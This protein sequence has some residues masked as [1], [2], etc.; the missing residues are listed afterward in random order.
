[1]KTEG[2]WNKRLFNIENVKRFSYAI[3]CIRLYTPPYTFVFTH[4]ISY[5]TLPIFVYTVNGTG[6]NINITLHLSAR[7]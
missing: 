2:L 5:S 1:M 6:C 7:C 4:T 3:V